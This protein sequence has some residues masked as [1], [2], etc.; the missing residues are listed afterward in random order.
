[1]TKRDLIA[2]LASLRDDEQI[3]VG[4]GDDLYIPVSVTVEP[5]GLLTVPSGAARRL[6]CAVI[7]IEAPDNEDPDNEDPD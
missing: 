7:H 5:F 1:M 4:I 2:A 6:K 3:R